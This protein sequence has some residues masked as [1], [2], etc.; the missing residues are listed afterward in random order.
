MVNICWFEKWISVIP[1]IAC[2]LNVYRLWGNPSINLR[3]CHGTYLICSLKNV[4]L[5]INL[6]EYISFEEI[7]WLVLG[8]ALK[9]VLL[10][11]RGIPWGGWRNVL[12]KNKQVICYSLLHIK[13]NPFRFLYGSCLLLWFF[14]SRLRNTLGNNLI[15]EIPF[16]HIFRYYSFFLNEQPL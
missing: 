15:K 9:R 2:W 10:N 14:C 12:R 3:T 1:C 5:D 16:I 4:D 11:G 13:W 8:Q 6:V 7:C